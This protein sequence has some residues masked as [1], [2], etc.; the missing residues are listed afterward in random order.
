MLP[1]LHTPS[2]NGRAIGQA[3]TCAQMPPARS[4]R[5]NH[6]R[7]RGTPAAGGTCRP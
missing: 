2:T 3:S 6:A 7:S 5:P 1:A 4:V